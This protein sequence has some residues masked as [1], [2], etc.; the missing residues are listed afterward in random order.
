MEGFFWDSLC[1]VGKKHI[2]KVVFV[3]LKKKTILQ[4]IKKTQKKIKVPVD[5]DIIPNFCLLMFF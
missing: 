3:S 4:Q 2:D 5:L 1:I